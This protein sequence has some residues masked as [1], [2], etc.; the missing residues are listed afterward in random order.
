M[1]LTARQVPVTR[2]REWIAARGEAGILPARTVQGR[3]ALAG[4]TVP[5]NAGANPAPV[6]PCG[7]RISS[8]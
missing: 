8:P 3:Q 6:N 1:T 4:S 7:Q 5:Q 2:A